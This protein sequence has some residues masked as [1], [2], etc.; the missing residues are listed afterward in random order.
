MQ[1]ASPV[2]APLSF[3]RASL[4]HMGLKNPFAA[5]KRSALATVLNVFLWV[6]MFGLASIL[7][8]PR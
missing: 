2:P 3:A 6:G 7:T 4:W 8:L 5:T 1:A